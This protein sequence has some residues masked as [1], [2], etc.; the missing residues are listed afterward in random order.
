MNKVIVSL[1][2]AILSACAHSAPAADNS[3]QQGRCPALPATFSE[4]DLVGTWGAEYGN[5]NTD[6]LILRGDGT[7]RQVYDDPVASFHY[8]SNWLK[9]RV[10]HR[11]S[12]YLRLHMAGMRRC[13]SVAS[14]CKSE[15]G[16]WVTT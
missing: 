13:D 2:A 7:Y 10:E 15:G 6:T 1:I 9:W 11:A 4:S 14:L 5:M 8:E 16:E 3:A 12:G